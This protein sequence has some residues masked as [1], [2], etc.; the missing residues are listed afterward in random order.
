MVSFVIQ[1]PIKRIGIREINC[2]IHLA[3]IY[4]VDS[5][6]WILL[7]T[8]RTTGPSSSLDQHFKTSLTVI[9]GL[10]GKQN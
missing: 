10:E 1:I 6:I 9:S 2:G 4:A 3:E 7:S 5:V 8:F